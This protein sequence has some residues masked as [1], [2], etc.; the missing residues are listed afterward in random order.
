MLGKDHIR[1]APRQS[2]QVT[3]DD[4]LSNVKEVA[5]RRCNRQQH[6]NRARGPDVGRGLSIYDCFHLR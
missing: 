3:D 2:K 6:G 1:F 5:Q 4:S